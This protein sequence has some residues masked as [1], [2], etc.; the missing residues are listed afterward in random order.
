MQPRC[1][2][3]TPELALQAYMA[4][5]AKNVD[6]RADRSQ[7]PCGF[8]KFLGVLVAEHLISSYFSIHGIS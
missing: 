8:V 2:Q 1:K 4:D 6:S 3:S 7:E 5:E